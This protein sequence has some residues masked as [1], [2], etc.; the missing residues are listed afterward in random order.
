MHQ[1][2]DKPKPNYPPRVKKALKI[3]RLLYRQGK[4]RMESQ[5][6][7]QLTVSRR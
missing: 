2:N 1:V 5:R 7:G 4:R 3:S 6:A